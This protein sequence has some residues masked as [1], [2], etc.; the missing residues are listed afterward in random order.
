MPGLPEH[1]EG[2]LLVDDVVLG[3]K[4]AELRAR[5]G[6]LE[7][8]FCSAV[9]DFNVAIAVRSALRNSSRRIGLVRDNAIPA[10]RQ[11]ARSPKCSQDVSIRTMLLSIPGQ[12]RI[13]WTRSKPSI[14]GMCMSV[15]TTS[16]GSPDCW[17]RSSSVS[18]SE[19][20]ATAVGRTP[21][22]LVHRRVRGGWSDYHQ[23]PVPADW[24]IDDSRLRASRRVALLRPCYR[25][26]KA[27]AFVRSHC[28]HRCCLPWRSPVEPISSGP[29]RCLHICAS[30]KHRPGQ[31]A[32]KMIFCLS[33][34]DADAQCLAPRSGAASTLRVGFHLDCQ[35]PLH[36]CR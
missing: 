5:V 30:W 12:V 1:G 17:L 29:D 36:R 14:S 2:N 24:L 35:Q 22:A 25:E 6:A 9:G 18:A 33:L 7:T 10:S 23:R 28:L 34:R 32:S 21:R 8:A 13:L 27:T 19:P 20:L 31:T 11:R 16:M 4:Y 15:S 26:V 3:Q